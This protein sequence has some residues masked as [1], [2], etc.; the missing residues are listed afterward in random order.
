MLSFNDLRYVPLAFYI[1]VFLFTTQN[2]G[3]FQCHIFQMG[4]KKMNILLLP[5][6]FT[7]EAFLQVPLPA[8]LP[9]LLDDG[10]RA[11]KARGKAAKSLDSL[12]TCTVQASRFS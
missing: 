12:L 1:N 9:R 7:A 10:E 2:W 8:N 3:R 11:R 6:N 5:H 4:Q